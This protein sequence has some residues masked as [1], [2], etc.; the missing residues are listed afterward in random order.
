MF[1]DQ[2]YNSIDDKA[3]SVSGH[4]FKTY[5]LKNNKGVTY[6][7]GTNKQW[8]II[9]QSRN[10]T[11]GFKAYAVA[12][13]GKDNK[14]DC[15]NVV[16][17]FAGTDG[18]S[19]TN[20]VLTD[21]ETI[22]LG[23]NKYIEPKVNQNILNFA[24]LTSSPALAALSVSF[25]DK[26]E[27]QSVDALKFYNRVANKVKAHGGTT[28]PNTSGHS[29][30][31]SLLM[32]VAVKKKVSCVTFNGPDA[33][34]MLTAKER[35]YIEI[36]P[37]GFTNY[38]NPYDLVGNITG[39]ETKSAN[40]V[41]SP[42][43]GPW[44]GHAMDYHGLD[45]WQ[46]DKSGNLL[47]TKG[48]PV[49]SKTNQEFIEKYSQTHEILSNRLGS[50]NSY[51]SSGTG[52]GSSEV[53]FLEVVAAYYLKDAIINHANQ[54]LDAINKTYIDG[55]TNQAKGWTDAKRAAYRIGKDLSS[56]EC[57][58]ALAAGQATKQTLV[59]AY[60]NQI[61][62]KQS[63][64]DGVRSEFSSFNTIFTSKIKEKVADDQAWASQF[65]I[66]FNS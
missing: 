32:Y 3:Y 47:T 13:I 64:I 26:G 25:Q 49:N 46:F 15:N 11:N 48:V 8:V 4:K 27:A 65:G 2:E 54:G 35:K 40:Y 24:K 45:K 50:L 5:D 53:I 63:T 10:D 16:V 43:K 1:T 36:H 39:N 37:M 6:N 34:N 29:L 52:Y 19:S 23:R 17:S 9:D 30:G 55:K 7:L 22:G 31:G 66:N 62:S 20:D 28:A 41:A 51:F 33:G 12:P 14:P 21:I 61:N 58:T 44:L 38:R 59:T 57:R 56:E 42:Y 18:A 60:T